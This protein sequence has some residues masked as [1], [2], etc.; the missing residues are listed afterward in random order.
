MTALSRLLP[1]ALLAFALL[2]ASSSAEGRRR[3]KKKRAQPKPPPAYVIERLDDGLTLVVMK[4]SG[5]RVSLRYAV[6][7]GGFQDP[8]DKS[9]AAHLV[10]HLIFHGSYDIPEGKL[11]ELARQ[12]GARVSARTHTTWTSFELDAPK[13]SFLELLDLYVR[14]VTNPALQ[15]ADLER[16]KQLIEGE[17]RYQGV[18][19]LVWALDQLAF[20][21]E[22]RGRT[23]LGTERSRESIHAEDLATFYE[24]HYTP[25]NTV[26]LVVGDVDVSALRAT[27]ERAV[28][29]PPVS[30]PER[31]RYDLE[32]NA[33]ASAKVRQT[34]TGT[35]S[36]YALGDVDVRLC[37]DI[38]AL[39]E[40]RVLRRVRWQQSI[41][42]DAL[43]RC[44]RL[45]GQSFVVA[46]ALAKDVFG[47]RLPKVLEEVMQGAARRPLSKEER[48]VLLS[49]HRS[50]RALERAEPER[51]ADALTE[52]LLSQG[53]SLEENLNSHFAPPR[54]EWP[55]M[56]AAMERALTDERHVLVHFSPYEG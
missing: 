32:P 27:L 10:E 30:A 28:L 41:A 51:L 4:A 49:R 40:L 37:E 23:L 17:R 2:V 48:R 5:E 53:G 12:R 34:F 29:Q 25:A 1:V 18:P 19:Q 45:R 46:Y 26:V 7:S 54:L 3:A 6:R 36:A 14:L 50:L 42:S 16:E 38:A 22:N 56:R 21:S 24:Q 33:P 52:R 9:G 13:E 11:E 35:A 20:P 39:L 15:F 43:V 8:E 31:R 47:S 44:E 55:A